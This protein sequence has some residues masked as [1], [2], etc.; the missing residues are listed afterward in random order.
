MVNDSGARVIGIDMSGAFGSGIRGGLVDGAAALIAKKEAFTPRTGAE[1]LIS[2]V[3]TMASRLAELSRREGPAPTAVGVAV[4]GL[5]DELTGV[6]HRS[7][8]L[9]LKE[10]RLGPILAERLELPVFLIHDTLA[11][12]L[13]ENTLGVGRGV[14]D[15]LL[16]V[17]GGGVGC[18]VISGGHLV[19]GAHGT[20]GEI[21]H[22]SVDPAGL[23][24]GCGGRG[25]VETIASEP[26]LVRRYT[27]ATSEA[28]PPE[29]VISRALAGHP[30]AT[31]VW[32]EALSALATVIA[33]AA[34]LLD[35]E[36]VVL[37]GPGKLPSSAVEPLRGLLAKRMNLV[38]PPRM[39]VGSLGDSAG[40]LGAATIAFERGGLRSVTRGWS[41]LQREGAVGA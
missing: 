9:S 15:L 25:C 10:V 14:R 8:N 20:A 1:D 40:V 7:P 41:E 17:I 28:I 33:S 29:E 31:R 5:V 36:L 6:V 16:V 38:Q 24:C 39:E 12:A 2:S 30:A 3:A 34:L 37:H 4:P 26:A 21:G 32:G 19:H 13:A 35:A 11:G 22:I 23:I 27:T 18:A